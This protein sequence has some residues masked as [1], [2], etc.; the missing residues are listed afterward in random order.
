MVLLRS[1]RKHFFRPFAEIA[2]AIGVAFP[3]CATVHPVQHSAREQIN[4][5][6]L[7][8][9]TQVI[10]AQAQKAQWQ[11]YRYTFNVFIPSMVANA[12]PCSS[13]LHLMLTS[14]PDMALSRMNYDVRCQSENGWKMNVS[15]RPDVFV[16]VVMPRSLIERN[17]EITA[18]DLEL[19]KFNI[20]N[21]H[22]N[23]LMHLEDVVGL[24]SKRVLQPGKPITGAELLQPM[25]V[26][27]DQPVMIVSHIAGISASMPGV[28]M[29]NGHKGDVIRVRN[30]SSQRVI[31]GIVDD[32]GVV[33]TLNPTP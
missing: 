1:E 3:A 22:G 20:S 10:E 14:P 30:T 9:A 12:A 27:R 29:K 17:T 13:S 33:E 5:Q 8:A 6:V 4:A 18:D 23:V 25:L 7:R 15:V 28:A 2:L 26:K 24:T 16:A 19:K 11:D 32:A 21:Q 31:S